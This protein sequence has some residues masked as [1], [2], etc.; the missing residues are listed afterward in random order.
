MLNDQI[1]NDIIRVARQYGIEPAALI[2]VVEVESRGTP[3]EPDGRTPRFLFERHVFYRELGA[4]APSKRGQ[5]VRE[6]L[7]NNGYRKGQYKDQGSSSGRAALLR[8]ARAIDPESANRSCSWGV[9]Q[10]MG[11]NSESLGFR[12]ATEMVAALSSGGAAAQI[13]LMV[14]YIRSR[15]ILDALNRHDWKRVALVYNGRDYRRNA[16]DTKLASAYRKWAATDVNKRETPERV[17]RPAEA[18]IQSTRQIEKGS[19][20]VEVEAVQQRLK[21]AGYAV[22]AVDGK[23]GTITQ[24]ALLAFQADNDLPQTGV[25]DA[26]TLQLLALAPERP[27]S[28]GRQHESLSDLRKKGSG[29]ISLSDWVKRLAVGTG[30]VGATGGLSDVSTGITSVLERIAGQGPQASGAQPIPNDAVS[31]VLNLAQGLIG[32]QAGL[33]LLTVGAAVMLF[34]GGR[35]IANRRLRDHRIGANLNR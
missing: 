2:A 24:G 5:A 3:F 32:T 21:D 9:G 1:V 22:G 23:F 25:V 6:G 12:S 35:N 15:G 30:V 31:T 13:D 33:G 27:I 29:T 34:R 28:G 16:Y 11:F 8:R 18:M 10:V 20:G 14:R 7:A 4:R 26:K 17:D 19:R